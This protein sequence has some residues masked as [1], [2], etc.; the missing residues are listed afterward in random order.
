M[1]GEQAAPRVLTISVTEPG[2]RVAQRLPFEHVHG[3]PAATLSA[4]WTDIDAFV[5]VLAL[6]ATVRL[7][8]PLLSNKESDPAVVCVDDAGS[9][10]ISV[11]GGH[12][13]G[14]NALAH[15]VAR[16]LGAQPVITTA[17]DRMAVPALDQLVGLRAEGD[18]ARV[19]AALLAGDAIEIDRELAWPLPASLTD[20]LARA[21]AP[22]PT[23]GGTGD[24]VRIVLSDRELRGTAKAGALVAL[25]PPSL[26]V[27]LGTT[28]DATEADAC[29]AVTAALSGAGLSPLSL[30]ALGTIDRRADHAAIAA[31]A[32]RW[33]LPVHTFGADRLDAIAVPTPSDV[34]ARAVGTHSV[35][36]AAALAAA[37]AGTELVVA[38]LVFDRVTVAIAR[39]SRPPGSLSIVGLGPGSVAHRTPEAARAVRHAEVVIGLDSYVEQ[40]SDL[41]TA[42]HDVRRFPIGAEMKRVRLALDLATEGRSVALVCS[43]DAGVYAMASPALELA[44]PALEGSERYG[45]VEI[46]VVPGVTAGLAAAALLGAPLGHDHLVISLSDLLTPWDV[47]EARVRAAAENDLVLV[48]YNPRSLR[49]TWQIEKARSVL[50]EHRSADT[51]VGVVTDAARPHEH[52]VLTTLGELDCDAVNMTTCLVIGSSATRVVSGRM[53]TARGYSA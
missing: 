40:C 2:R 31:V 21:G 32:R 36:E 45:G 18:V 8:S 39:R 35:A 9:F 27:G 37:G 11:C 19:T 29:A 22:G 49:R 7:V 46:S 4:R 6:G 24:P 14:A 33:H 17:T 1:S 13:G 53:V 47:I 28:S 25:R 3:E 42:A 20:Q 30:G 52:V 23:D 34:V 44:D 43:G 10:A 15:E 48:V 26:V 41:L 38:K 50:L 12:A 51:P 16:L 5:M